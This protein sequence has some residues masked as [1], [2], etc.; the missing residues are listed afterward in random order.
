MRPRTRSPTDSDRESA[1]LG[2]VRDRRQRGD[3]IKL[4]TIAQVAE[5]LC[6]APRTVHRWIRNDDLIAHRV[7]RVVRI[8]ECDLR[9][10]LAA[11]REA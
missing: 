8:A 1:A 4:F 2:Q 5:R 11:H 3:Q 9:A 7:G 10:F 6:V